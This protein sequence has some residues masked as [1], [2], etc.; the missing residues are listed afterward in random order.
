MVESRTGNSLYEK[1]LG[2]FGRREMHEFS[3]MKT[4]ALTDAYSVLR[5]SLLWLFLEQKDRG[6]HP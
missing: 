1:G 5:K 4:Q 3:M 6:N 2:P